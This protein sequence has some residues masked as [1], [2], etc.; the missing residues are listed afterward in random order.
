MHNLVKEAT[1][2]DFNK[3]GDDLSTAKEVTLRT[4]EI[5]REN[6]NKSAIEACSSVG[7]VLNEVDAYYFVHILNFTAL[8]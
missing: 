5:G 4:I 1:G 7:H 2:I 8:Q 3:F 6:L